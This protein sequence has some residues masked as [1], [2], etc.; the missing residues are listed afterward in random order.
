[1]NMGE[2]V[3]HLK[4]HV[5]TFYNNGALQRASE[6]PHLKTNQKP[7]QINKKVG[8]QDRHGCAAPASGSSETTGW[9]NADPFRRRARV[10]APVESRAG[11]AGQGP[12][13]SLVTP[14]GWAI[15]PGLRCRGTF[16]L[17]RP[18]LRAIHRLGVEIRADLQQPGGRSGT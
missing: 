1:M 9:R 13:R 14:C 8:S 12:G 3:S 4:A 2:E 6:Q 5:N 18:S 16:S 7:S 17:R 11:M 15:G 10:L